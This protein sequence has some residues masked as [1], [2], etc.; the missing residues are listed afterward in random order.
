MDWFIVMVGLSMVPIAVIL[1]CVVSIL[2]TTKKWYKTKEGKF[3]Q[4]LRNV[5]DYDKDYYRKLK[6]INSELDTLLNLNKISTS[7]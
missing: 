3:Q 4:D 1:A 7:D 5:L 6:K 2:S